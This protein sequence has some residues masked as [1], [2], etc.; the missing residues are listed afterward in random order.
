MLRKILGLGLIVVL[1]GG[2]A[3]MVVPPVDERYWGTWVNEDPDTGGITR[4][5]IAP[6][7]V[8]MWGSCEPTDCDWGEAP[9][10]I[11]EDELRVVWEQG[12]VVQ[13]QILEIMPGGWLE[14]ETVSYFTDGSGTMAMTERFLR[15]IAIQ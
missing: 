15:E 14:V 10:A 6:W 7:T 4:I 11:H 8:H 3:P 2:C 12:F 9:Y 5:E 1:L 13:V